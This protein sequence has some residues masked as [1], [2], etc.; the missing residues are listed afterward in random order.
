MKPSIAALAI[1][2]GFSAAAPISKTGKREA[3]AK[4]GTIEARQTVSK[5]IRQIAG[6]DLNDALERLDT[7]FDVIPEVNLLDTVS[8]RSRDRF[9]MMRYP[10][11]SVTKGRQLIHT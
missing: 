11:T 2:V 9:V 5:G 3:N 1:L 6:L 10:L 8:S 4:R 7:L